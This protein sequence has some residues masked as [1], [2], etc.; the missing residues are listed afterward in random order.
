M[1]ETAIL[2][3]NRKIHEE[4]KD[5][6][7][8]ENDFVCL[9]SRHLTLLFPQWERLGLQIIAK[10]S[11]A[12][13][14]WNISMSLT[15]D[16]DALDDMSQNRGGWFGNANPEVRPPWKSYIFCSDQLPE[17]CRFLVEFRGANDRFLRNLVLC[18]DISPAVGKEHTT[19]IDS[20]PAGRTR[21]RKFFDP[22]RQLHSL[23]AVQIDGPLS[24]SYKSK[25][26]TSVCKPCPTAMAIIHETV[27]SLNK[28]DELANE[29]QFRHAKL[30]YNAALSLIRSCCWRYREQEFTMDEGPFPGLKAFQAVS[31]LV[32]RLQARI[33][34]VY[35][36][37]EK[38][39]MARIY[40]D[41]AMDPRRPI[42]RRG[43]K[44]YYLEIKPWEGIVYAEVLHVAAII[45][46]THGDVHEA[47]RRL[48]EAREFVL[49]NE[50]QA[51]RYKAW[52]A[53]AER[54]RERYYRRQETRS[55]QK[56]KQSEKL[57]SMC[58]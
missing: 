7:R 22:L 4:A 42:D 30:E 11:N 53:H 45:S 5:L 58:S 26:I 19:E 33:A 41:R 6:C 12:R 2:A 48:R 55:K 35:L 52:Q 56:E 49:F 9:T 20:S 16:G 17:L 25:V 46:Y 21:M 34:V 14:F 57:E 3:T 24:G 38:L 27:I 28:A 32:V 54:L 18:V 1:F 10:R 31:N 23:G 13:S 15:L 43:N 51:S 29:G 36:R 44:E 37:S 50:E 8:R 40:T 47:I 39:R